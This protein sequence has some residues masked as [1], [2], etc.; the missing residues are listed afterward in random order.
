MKTKIDKTYIKDLPK[1]DK[2]IVNE[3]LKSTDYP[4][5]MPYLVKTPAPYLIDF[6]GYA[7]KD[8]NKI[9]SSS[10]KEVKN[11]YKALDMLGITEEEAR[12]LDLTLNEITKEKLLFA[13]HYVNY[14][15]N[16]ETAMDIEKLE[17]LLNW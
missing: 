2:T 16:D 10:T 8:R 6:D 13:G 14:G 1:A 4:V 11:L 7:I 15:C 5:F 17:K 3:L 9:I 12:L